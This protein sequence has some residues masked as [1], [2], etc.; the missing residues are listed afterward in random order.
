MPTFITLISTVAAFS[1]LISD[2]AGAAG[3][4]GTIDTAAHSA[5]VCHDATCASPVPGSINFRPT[6]AAPVTIDD[7]AGVDGIAWGDELGWIT[8]DPTGP[9]GLVID[10][11]TGH[12]SG[13]A[14]SQVGGW[15]NFR[16]TGRGVSIDAEGEF[17][18]WAWAGGPY[19]GWI[20]FDCSDPASC[21]RTD[22]RPSFSRPTPPL[23]KGG[24]NGPIS[25]SG[26]GG[27]SPNDLCWNVDGVQFTVPEG[28]ER[29]AQSCMPIVLDACQN[30]PGIQTTAPA[31]YIADA[32]GLCR[33]IVD[34]CSNLPGIQIG[35]PAGLG[36]DLD[37]ACVPTARAPGAEST[38]DVAPR[39]D[40]AAASGLA[41]ATAQPRDVGADLAD[42]CANVVGR[43]SRIPDGYTS[44]ALSSCVPDRTDYCPNRPGLQTEI[45]SGWIISATGDCRLAETAREPR[46]ST[47]DAVGL[48]AAGSIGSV[49][50]ALAAAAAPLGWLVFLL[51]F[52]RWGSVIDITSGRVLRDVRLVL[53]DEHDVAIRETTTDHAGCYGFR[54]RPGLYRLRVRGTD[55]VLSV[56]PDSHMYDGGF[57]RVG[58][59]GRVSL[60]IALRPSSPQSLAHDDHSGTVI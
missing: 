33:L 39:N 12:I 27:A 9:D 46:E 1:F 3:A 17:T 29:Q 41:A 26:A 56:A 49:V 32:G 57:V 34:H 19:G 44:D 55:H 15:I 40:A 7:A 35:V 25:P 42:L 51:F 50:G 30:L 36:V 58:W 22:W 47:T 52:R 18:G 53:H 48:T 60:D 10:P 4:V 23:T 2:M 20:K 14:W 59:T 16:P 5:L 54:V 21:V 31:A 43:Q 6:S 8:F 13:K 24:D 28:Y 38:H 45:P 11:A 37:G